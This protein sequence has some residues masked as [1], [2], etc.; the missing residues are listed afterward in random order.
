MKP[1]NIFSNKYCDFKNTYCQFWLNFCHCLKYPCF[2]NCFKWKGKTITN[3]S[4]LKFFKMSATFH[5]FSIKKLF[6]PCFFLLIKWWNQCKSSRINVLI[7]RI[8][9]T[10]LILNEERKNDH[11]L[12]YFHVFQNAGF[13]RIFYVSNAFT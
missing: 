5:L 4:I 8:H 9:T 11:Q 10:I 13:L 2:E 7:L 3:Q 6:Q 1:I 12:K